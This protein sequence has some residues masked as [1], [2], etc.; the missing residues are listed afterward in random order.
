[1]YLIYMAS[2]FNFKKKY[3][4][5]QNKTW[6]NYFSL[7]KIRDITKKEEKNDA[8]YSPLSLS[9]YMHMRREVL[10]TVTTH[11]SQFIDFKGSIPHTLLIY[12]IC[13]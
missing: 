12:F 11:L 4:H 10:A 1:M 2:I 8:C 3:E 6:E 5:T 9:L 7:M 13:L